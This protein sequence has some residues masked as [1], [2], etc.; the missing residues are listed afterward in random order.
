[1]AIYSLEAMRDFQITFEVACRSDVCH[2]A[3]LD[4]IRP[5]IEGNS[6]PPQKKIKTWNSK[7]GLTKMSGIPMAV[8]KKHKKRKILEFQNNSDKKSLEFQ[9]PLGS[10]ELKKFGIPAKPGIPGG[11]E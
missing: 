1:M 7:T 3:I 6:P 10:H 9:H 4:N 5:P 8:D 11:Q 2:W